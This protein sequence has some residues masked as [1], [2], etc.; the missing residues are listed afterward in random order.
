MDKSFEYD[1]IG[2]WSEVKLDIV[3][4]Y[5][6]AYTTILSK[7]N[8]IKKYIYVDAFAGA[9]KHVSKTSGG[10]II[11]SPLN[12]L[13]VNPPFSEIHLID[14]HEGKAAELRRIVGPQSNVFIYQGDSNQVL[15]EKV[16]PRCNYKDYAR[17]LCFLD[18][19][20]LNVDWNVLSQAGQAKSVE[21]FYNFMIMDANMNALWRNP[22]EVSESQARRFDK[23]W[24]NRS[25]K[26]ETYVEQSNLFGESEYLKKG[27]PTIAE[28]FRKR[29]EIAAGFKYVPK[30][31]PMR[32]KNG[33]IIY[34]LY[35]ATQNETGAKIVDGIF[36]KYRTQGAV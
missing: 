2:P 16:F 23:I 22:D 35:F 32:N 3:K 7:Q 13:N 33:A 4:Q 21:V 26:K 19:Y 31:V 29:L 34:Y 36:E 25:W 12:A 27:N 5:A 18:P 6:A 20:G 24:G 17:A 9:G 11:G 30:P 10:F 1:E 14:L 8:F 15:L 28:S